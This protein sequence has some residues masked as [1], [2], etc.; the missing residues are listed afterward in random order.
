MP[1]I[2]SLLQP[3]ASLL[4]SKQI[5]IYNNVF[6]LHTKITV[7]LLLAFSVLVSAKEYFGTPIDCL[8]DNKER[9]DFVDNLCWING[10]YT[11][12]NLSG[13]INNE[14]CRLIHSYKAWT[15]SYDGFMII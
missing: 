11:F 7:T 3:F 6:K 12:R 2:F 10:T 14:R 15:K 8:Y 5:D 9:K 4:K 1:T 13:E